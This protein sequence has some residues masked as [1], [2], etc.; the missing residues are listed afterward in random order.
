MSLVTEWRSSP[1]EPVVVSRMSKGR[2]RSLLI[3]SL[4]LSEEPHIFEG[5]GDVGP[6]VRFLAVHHDILS[7]GVGHSH[8]SQIDTHLPNDFLSYILGIIQAA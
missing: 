6:V 7:A 1:A 8:L 5:P 4:C 3:L 2:P